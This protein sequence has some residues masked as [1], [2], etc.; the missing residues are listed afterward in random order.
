M[1]RKL[2]KDTYYPD[3]EAPVPI[4]DFWTLLLQSARYCMGRT[5]YAVGECCDHV[6]LYS[7][8][9]LTWQVQQIADEVERQ[10]RA[11]EKDGRALGMDCDHRDWTALVEWCRMEVARRGKEEPR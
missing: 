6:R 3:L 11:A 10:L 1:S 8:H 2:R 5:S 9:L 7:R 4:G